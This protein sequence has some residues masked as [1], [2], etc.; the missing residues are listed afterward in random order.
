MYVPSLLW[1]VYIAVYIR[2]DVFVK[3]NVC[4][5]IIQEK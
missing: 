3:R 2:V 1:N 4:V 5:I